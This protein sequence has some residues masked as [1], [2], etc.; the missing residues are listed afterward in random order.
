MMKIL[1]CTDGSPASEQAALL[2]SK[3]SFPPETGYTVLGVSEVD[4]DQVLLTVSFDR[5]EVL[6]GG[7]GPQISR[8][9]RYGSPI[10]EINGEAVEGEYD[11]I[12]LSASGKRRGFQMLRIGST[13]QKLARILTTPFL[14]A[15]NVPEKINKVLMCTGGESASLE[16]VKTAGKFLSNIEGEVIVL[17]VMSQVAL[18]LDSPTQDLMDTAETAIQRGT[19]E[20]RHLVEAIEQL[21]QAGVASQ[22]KP[23]IRH[24]LVVDE[25]LA[26]LSEGKYDLLAVG[27]HY[28]HG[29]SHWIEFLLEDISGQL[30]D[31]A[32]CS[33][34]IV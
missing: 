18:R 3:L 9:M 15:R 28:H 13:A 11:L 4:G 23:G 8:K 5:I 7:P 19:R 24:G 30:V 1:V 17:H 21:S 27:G 16:N 32:P 29:R 31:K 12:V 10:E 14:V 22:I 6:L 33:V 26:E 34:L 2:V 25:V 20:G